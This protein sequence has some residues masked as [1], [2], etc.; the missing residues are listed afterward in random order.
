MTSS[1]NEPFERLV[2]RHVDFVYSA[3]LRQVR[4]RHL[5][6]DVTQ[7]VFIILMR[8][9]KSVPE[10]ALPGWLYKT[11]RYAA[12]NALKMEIRRK[13][14]E[15]HAAQQAP[16][17]T[18]DTANWDVIEGDIDGAVSNLARGERDVILLHYF[19]GQTLLDTAISLGISHDAARKRASRA[20]E[21]LRAFFTGRGLSLSAVSLGWLIMSRS[22]KAAPAHMTQS[23]LAA[24]GGTAGASLPADAIVRQMLHNRAITV[25][26]YGAIAA[27]IG[28]AAMILIG[29]Q[30]EAPAQAHEPTT[31]SIERR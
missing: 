8:K 15:S 23:V 14:H 25:V 20:L 11:T 31:Q 30:N 3:A 1:G 10:A 26:K 12:K 13:I 2:A 9:G 5:A 27:T 16:S 7:A 17:H 19:N 18:T 29:M 4:D 21:R 22:A 28:V 6:E 24:A